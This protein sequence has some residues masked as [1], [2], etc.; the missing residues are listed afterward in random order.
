MAS[1]NKGQ[2]ISGR[3][4]GRTVGILAQAGS[5]IRSLLQSP[6]TLGLRSPRLTLNEPHHTT[7]LGQTLGLMQPQQGRRQQQQQRGQPANAAA[8][9]QVNAEELQPFRQAVGIQAGAQQ[10][11]QQGVQEKSKKRGVQLKKAAE[12]ITQFFLARAPVTSNEFGEKAFSPGK[13]NVNNA[14]R[15]GAEA[16][17][18]FVDARHPQ[19]THWRHQ[20]QQWLCKVS[21]VDSVDDWLAVVRINPD[22]LLAFLQNI[23]FPFGTQDFPTA[24]E[25]VSLCSRQ[26]SSF[27]KCNLN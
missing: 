8:A 2:A 13:G 20:A 3:T 25:L 11:A 12:A 9:N 15:Q 27:L 21:E 6:T 26:V 17:S 14:K 5:N 1:K 16:F 4:P 7:V 24:D 23:N 18:Q 19:L 22:A 10:E